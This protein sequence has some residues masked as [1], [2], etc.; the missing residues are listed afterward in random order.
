MFCK[1][2]FQTV[3]TVRLRRK[4]GL[5]K[6]QEKWIFVNILVGL[7]FFKFKISCI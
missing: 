1:I 7:S 5:Q 4:L 2:E 3:I 6:N